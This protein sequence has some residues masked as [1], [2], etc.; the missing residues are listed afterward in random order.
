MP[1]FPTSN[2]V[3]P[4]ETLPADFFD[5]GPP[6]ELPPDFFEKK[7]KPRTPAETSKF[8]QERYPQYA[9]S[10]PVQMLKGAGKGLLSQFGPLS[11]SLGTK[12]EEP[13]G[14]GEEAGANALEGTEA[15]AAA[16]GLMYGGA[17]HLL[18]RLRPPEVPVQIARPGLKPPKYGGPKPAFDE[19]ASRLPPRKGFTPPEATAAPGKG[20]RVKYG[21]PAEPSDGGASR[22]APRKPAELPVEEP[23]VK[24]EPFK[25]SSRT[26]KL[27][28]SGGPPERFDGG[29]RRLAPKAPAGQ[30]TAAEALPGPGKKLPASEPKV[31][32]RGEAEH[33]VNRADASTN[34]AKE[35]KRQGLDMEGYDRL[36]E[37]DPD[38]LHTL[39]KQLGHNE[40]SHP[41]TD[42]GTWHQVR[43]RLKWMLKE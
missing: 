24:T 27:T 8:L 12:P 33:A 20:T 6:T 41:G 3:N 17:R 18:R 5:K 4:P 2:N 23:F 43:V 7:T 39:A 29:A 19:G 13:S 35:L 21:G 11:G 26:A 28:K 31:S 36:L 22:L 38:A 42:S 14:S 16:G 34:I 10:V 30:T 9:P 37:K 1:Q 40:V 32:I 25:T 15:L